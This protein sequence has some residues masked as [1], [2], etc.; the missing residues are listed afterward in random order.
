MIVVFD[1]AWLLSLW[2]ERVVQAALCDEG[3]DGSRTLFF[4]ADF[5]A[6]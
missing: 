2:I 5:Y 6:W 4:N 3:D 1:E